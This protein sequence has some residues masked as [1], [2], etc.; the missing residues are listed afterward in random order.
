MKHPQY[1]QHLLKLLGYCPYTARENVLSLFPSAPSVSLF[2]HLQYQSALQ[3]SQS[4]YSFRQSIQLHTTSENPLFYFSQLPVRTNWIV[5]KYLVYMQVRVQFLCRWKFCTSLSLLFLI[6]WKAAFFRPRSI[7]AGAQSA[8]FAHARWTCSGACACAAS[9]LSASSASAQLLPSLR[10]SFLPDNRRGWGRRGSG[11]E[12][13][14]SLW[15]AC[16]KDGPADI[17]TRG[18]G[19]KTGCSGHPKCYCDREYPVNN[20][21]VKFAF[22]FYVF[23]FCTILQKFLIDQEIPQSVR[24][25]AVR[26]FIRFQWRL[27]LLR[28]S[29]ASRVA[30]WSCA[31]CTTRS[32]ALP[33]KHSS[34]S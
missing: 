18:A 34:L 3:A 17:R 24:L 28:V 13:S 10:R 5:L 29:A 9:L 7:C 31:T 6:L 8:R 15:L 2:I 1:L 33:T 25:Q 20:G 32:S 4:P 11:A 19:T 16:L 12:S 26:D 22:L 30:W 14:S 27:F 21:G 23:L